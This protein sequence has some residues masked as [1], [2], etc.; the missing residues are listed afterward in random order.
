MAT[1]DFVSAA[2]GDVR[3]GRVP[4]ECWRRMSGRRSRELW[5]PASSGPRCVCWRVRG[6]LRSRLARW[7]SEAGLTTAAVYNHFGGM[8]ELRR[9]V[10]EARCDLL[11]AE[12]ARRTPT[13]DPLADV[14]FLAIRCRDFA[15]ASPHRYD[16]MFGLSV[17]GSYRAAVAHVEY[18]WTLTC[19][20]V[21]TSTS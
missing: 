11:A 18:E 21:R 3:C 5:R 14:Y 19:V 6:P 9:A 17:R 8:P 16:L 10:S 1:A 2:H 20:S 7:P 13:D 15:H 12:F 4:G